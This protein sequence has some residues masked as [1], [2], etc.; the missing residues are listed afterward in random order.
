MRPPRMISIRHSRVILTRPRGRG[1]LVV[2][3]ETSAPGLYG[4]G[5]G[6]FTQRFRAVKS[7]VEDDLKPLLILSLIHISE[8]T[9]PY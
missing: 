1:L 8:P 9:R 6:T 7:A 3:V 5:C 2:K 4:L